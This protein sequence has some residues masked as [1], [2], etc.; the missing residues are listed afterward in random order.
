MTIKQTVA[1]KLFV[2]VVAIAMALS[3]V[4]PAQA[5]TESEMEATIAALQAQIEAL[6]GQVGQS[7]TGG[8]SAS[9]CP[10]AWTRSLSSG[11]TGADVM[12]LQKFLNADA[13]TQV[14]AAGNVGSAGMETEYYGPAT[15]AAVSNFQVLYRDSILT[16][17]GLV[18]PTGYFGPSTMAKANALCATASVGDDMMD[19]D[20]DSS[21][22]SD[23]DELSG[24]EAD[25][26]SLE[27]RD[28]E[29]EIAEGEEDVPVHRVEFD[30]EDGDVRLERMDVTLDAT[31]LVG[32]DGEAD[33]WDAFDEISIWVDGDKVASEDVSDEDDWDE[34]TGDEFVFRITNIDT[35]FREDTTGEVIIALTAAGS[36]DVDG[37]SGDDDW[38][39]FVDTDGMR[40]IDSLGLDIEDGPGSTDKSTFEMTEASEGDDLALESSDDDPD[41]TTFAVDEDDE[42]EIMIFAFDL[43]AE[44]SDNDIELDKLYINAHADGTDGTSMNAIVDDF[45][46]EID[47]DSFDA[48]SYTGTSKQVNGIW[49]DIDGD[50]TIDADEKVTVMVYANLNDVASSFSDATIQA[51]TTA[52]TVDAEG[53]D[54]VTATGGTV[55]GNVHTLRLTGVDAELVS[56]DTTLD[57]N[58]DTKTN[59][60]EGEFTIEF[61]LT[62]FGDDIYVPFGAATAT[63]LTS[64]FEFSILDNSNNAVDLTGAT[65]TISVDIEDGSQ[66][67]TNSYKINEGTTETFTLTVKYGP[68]ATHGSYKLQL[69]TVNFALTDVGTATKAQDVSDLDIDTAKQ[70]I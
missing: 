44:D 16:P 59:D 33:P 52:S 3:L 34:N 65:T 20:D 4:A 35:I 47:G 67:K 46:I 41:A 25:V 2:G 36:V 29:D 49:F 63:D 7:S 21:D 15:A 14:A 50:V 31:A 6:L 66:E 37:D 57:E 43:S 5:A 51:S 10:Y 56:E 39:I 48:E 8:S 22:D 13:A 58:D 18:N 17:V 30:V 70:T 32:N 9:V 23:S 28:E 60:D 24:G 40:F 19:D 61:D 62:A 42:T 38:D 27:G 69:D 12:A 11:S 55:E 45:R 54:D 1:S 26:T 64:G 53:A 68:G